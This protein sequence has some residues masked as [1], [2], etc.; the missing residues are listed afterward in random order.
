MALRITEANLAKDTDLAKWCEDNI[1]PEMVAIR[2]NRQPMDRRWERYWRIWLARLD[3]SSY[4]GRTK[5]Y[6]AAG[7]R[8][9]ETVAKRMKASFF[10]ASGDWMSVLP[11]EGVSDDE[12]AAAMYAL[13]KHFLEKTM[14][15]RHHFMPFARQLA[16]IGN[17]PYKHGWFEVERQIKALE[18]YRDDGG[19]VGL[20]LVME[21]LRTAGPTFRVVPAFD[22]Y[23]HPETADD[24]EDLQF[25]FEDKEVRRS[26]IKLMGERLLDKE[27]EGRGHFY[28]NT[29]LAL[30]YDSLPPGFKEERE[31]RLKEQGITMDPARRWTGIAKQNAVLTEGYWE[32]AIRPDDP[33]T[34]PVTGE[35]LD[36]VRRWLVAFVADTV[37]VRL[38]INP[39]YKQTIPYNWVRSLRV[40]DEFY[41]HAIAEAFD[42]VQYFLNDLGNQFGDSA[43]IAANPIAIIDPTRHTRPN[44][45]R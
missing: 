41:G 37:C 32:G 36:G 38:S 2:D 14:R 16:V 12:M 34:D 1:I 39:F 35:K 19:E 13:Q 18:R 22:C 5:M 40:P 42:R 17:S 15:L 26:D 9:Q 6:L 25:H 29:E 24:V 28:E 21:T 43:Q 4:S 45:F 7:R 44:T 10:A 8:V 33:P 30:K 3:R 23:V 27:E 20:K 31:R 11:V